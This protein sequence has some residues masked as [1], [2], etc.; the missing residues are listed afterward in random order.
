MAH[1]LVDACT[2]AFGKTFIVEACRYGSVPHTIVITNLV[3]FQCIHTCMYMFCHLVEYTGVHF[4]ALPDAL[5]L[6][7]SQYQVAGRYEFAF[8]LPIHHLLIQLGDSLRWVN[9][10]SSLLLK[11]NCVCF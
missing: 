11:H 1:Y 5:Y 7:G 8:V 10:P 9:V 6:L 4:A 2:H 3:Y